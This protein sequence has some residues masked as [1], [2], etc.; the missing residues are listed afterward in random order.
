MEHRHW[1]CEATQP[2]RDH[3]TKEHLEYAS[4]LPECARERAWFPEPKETVEYKNSLYHIPDTTRQWEP[5]VVEAKCVD[6]F[7]DGTAI[8]PAI[9]EARLVAWSAVVSTSQETTPLAMGG[10]PGQWQSVLRAEITAVISALEWTK[11]INKD[12]RIWCDNDTVVKEFRKFQQKQTWTKPTGCDHDLWNRMKHAIAT[13]PGKCTII[14]IDSH[15]DETI[16]DTFQ[17]WVFAGNN[18]ADTIAKIA[19]SFLPQVVVAKQQ[20]AAVKARQTRAYNGILL[21][22]YA[23]IGMFAVT[24][25]APE[26]SRAEDIVPQ[27]I[28]HSKVICFK[29]IANTALNAPDRLKVVGF[30]KIIEW[31]L[32]LDDP[33]PNAIVYAVTWLELLWS[34][35]AAA[36]IRSFISAG[37][38]GQ[39]T[40]RDTKQEYDILKE[41]H[42][43][44]NYIIALTRLEYPTFKP[45]NAKPSNYRYQHW[46]MCI[47]FRWNENNRNSVMTWLQSQ[48]GSRQIKKVHSDVIDIP[49][50]FDEEPS[51]GLHRFFK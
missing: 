16:A 28:D 9:P 43:F 44:A 46:A 34:F 12:I 4:T 51:V 37:C 7:T 15:Q 2:F 3:L 11:H 18:A 6:V 33:N 23:K 10:V 49:P 39:W 36:N 31:M 27:L 29:D 5:I 24:N 19:I 30:H 13:H 32:S 21:D 8:D 26:Q 17:Q 42:A 50:A 48:I 35:Q 14:K 1:Q 47:Y 45:I 25:K 40:I 41:S 22:M 20:K 38:H